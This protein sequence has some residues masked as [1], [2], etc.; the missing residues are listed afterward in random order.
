VMRRRDAWE[1][2]SRVAN[3]RSTSS[4]LRSLFLCQFCHTVFG[5]KTAVVVSRDLTVWTALGGLG[6]RQQGRG[7]RDEQGSPAGG[8][9]LGR[10]ERV[11]I[12]GPRPGGAVDSR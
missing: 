12:A 5:A 3:S 8:A 11:V 4:F 2:G 7:T 6:R 1:I 9:K 10:A